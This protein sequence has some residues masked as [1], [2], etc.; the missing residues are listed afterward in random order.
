MTGL[1][2]PARFAPLLVG[3]REAIPLE[4]CAQRMRMYG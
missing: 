2:F 4:P 1:F 3:G